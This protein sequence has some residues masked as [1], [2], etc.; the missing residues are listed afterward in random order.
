VAIYN[1]HDGLLAHEIYSQI[2]IHQVYGGVVPELASRDHIKKTL[3]LV[4]ASLQSVDF[5]LDAIDGIAYTRGPGLIGALMVGASVAHGLAYARS[6][7]VIGVHHMEAHLMAVMLEAKKPRYPFIA[8]IVSGG[9]TMLLQVNGFG[10]YRLLGETL[11]DAVG[12]AF[13]K[14]ASLL[15]LPYPGGPALARLAEQGDPKRFTFPRPMVN[16]PGLDFSFSGLK[17]FALNCVQSNPQD[18]QTRADIA[19]AFEAA[20]VDTLLI[21]SRRA[22]EAAGMKQLVVAGGVSANQR[23]RQQFSQQL[24]ADIFFPRMEFCTDNAAM[25]AYIGHERL[26]RGESSPMGIDPKPRW[27]ID[28]I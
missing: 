23:L 13:D 21:K 6:C 1:S 8:L 25:V 20:A 7:P 16:R 10:D 11:D 14:T 5:T 15:G 12:E 28:Q 18:Q 26:Q 2:D 19:Y 22:L 9:H 24:D 4:Q 27:P 17:T 3:P